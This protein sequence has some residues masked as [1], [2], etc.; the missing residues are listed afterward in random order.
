[1]IALFLFS[2][3]TEKID[4]MPLDTNKEVKGKTHVYYQV[5]IDS[6]DCPFI[7]SISFVNLSTV[8]HEPKH[9]PKLYFPKLYFSCLTHQCKIKKIL[10]HGIVSCHKDRMWNSNQ[11]WDKLIMMS[12]LKCRQI[13]C[14]VANQL[15]F[16]TTYILKILF[17]HCYKKTKR[18]WEK[19]TECQCRV[20]SLT[21]FQFNAY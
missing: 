5:L 12:Y 1:M 21:L 15:N 9:E 4:G 2:R 17:N 20:I 19:L 14:F 16:G 6:R 10:F 7:V 8:K 3:P 11:Y 18:C 13:A